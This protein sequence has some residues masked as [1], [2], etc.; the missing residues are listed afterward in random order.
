MKVLYGINSQCNAEGGINRF[1]FVMRETADEVGQHGFLYTCQFISIDSAVVLQPFIRADLN[2]SRQTVVFG[3]N[4]GADYRGEIIINDFLPGNDQKNPV[5]LW[6]IL[7]T[8]VDPVEIAALHEPD[9][10]LRRSKYSLWTSHRNSSVSSAC[11]LSL[12]ALCLKNSIS[13]SAVNFRFAGGVKVRTTGPAGISLG[14][15]M[16]SLWL[17][18][19]STVCV[20]VMRS[21]YRKKEKQTSEELTNEE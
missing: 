6:V 1:H 12:S 3:I 20:I 18:G 14:T 2:L 10:C 8:P 15:S 11:L 17:A 9:S 19:I 16:V 4:R 5:I 13:S 7:R 21:L